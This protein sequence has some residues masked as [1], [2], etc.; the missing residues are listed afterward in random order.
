M[1]GCVD[2]RKTGPLRGDLGGTL[3]TLRVGTS[4]PA[5]GALTCADSYDL[6]IWIPLKRHVSFLSIS[7]SADFGCTSA[8]AGFGELAPVS[9]S[10]LPQLLGS[11]RTRLSAIL[12]SALQLDEQWMTDLLAYGEFVRSSSDIRERDTRGRL[13]NQ[14]GAHGCI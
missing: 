4:C 11:R 13:A 7:E 12:V 9:W 6:E 5:L 10:P 2:R 1:G 3:V 8:R 14:G